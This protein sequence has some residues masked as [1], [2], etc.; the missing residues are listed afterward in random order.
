MKMDLGGPSTFGTRTRASKSGKTMRGSFP[1]HA[2]VARSEGTVCS[3]ESMT[4][5]QIIMSD[6]ISLHRFPQASHSFHNTATKEYV[7]L[8][9]HIIMVADK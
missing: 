3:E 9:S 5:M 7:D 4:E 8:L 6:R 2:L 1:C